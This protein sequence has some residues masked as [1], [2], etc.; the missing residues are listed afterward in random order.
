MTFARALACAITLAVSASVVDAQAR[1]NRQMPGRGGQPGRPDA[2]RD[3]EDEV[4]RNFA[5]AVRERVGL[6]DDQMVKLGPITRKFEDQRRQ[7]QGDE[8]D[9]RMKLMGLVMVNAEGDSVRI[10]QHI[11][12]LYEVR[13]RRMQIDEAEQKDLA[14]IMTPLQLAKFLA[15]QENVRRRLEQARPFPGGPPDGMPPGQEPGMPVDSFVVRFAVTP[16]RGVIHVDG[17]EQGRG[18]QAVRLPVGWHRVTFSAA[19]CD[20]HNDSILVTRGPMAVMTR[21]LQSNGADCK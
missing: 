9:A 15:L 12:E 19:G 4:R 14:A 2:R 11:A 3:L 10:K 7:V 21:V 18:R 6:S 17:V 1:P 13:R 20:V 16:L 8:R 5:R